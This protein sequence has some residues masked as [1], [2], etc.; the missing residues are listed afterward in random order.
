[1]MD[2]EAWLRELGL[3]QYAEAF[4][5]NDIDGDTLARLTAEDLT[6][7]GRSS[8]PL[9]WVQTSRPNAGRSR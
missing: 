7:I 1:M 3:E 9:R 8:P 6:D 5:Q 4:A 2:V